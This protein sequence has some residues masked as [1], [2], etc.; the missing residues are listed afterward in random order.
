MTKSAASLNTLTFETEPAKRSR[1]YAVLFILCLAAS[2]LT[3]IGLSNFA[4]ANLI[5]VGEYPMK[6][7]YIRSSGDVDPATMQFIAWATST[8]LLITSSTA[9]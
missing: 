6:H 4:K 9:Q 3:Q 1:A 7:A 5:Y 2:A 8:F